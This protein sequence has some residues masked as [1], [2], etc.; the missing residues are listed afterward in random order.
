MHI[1][2]IYCYYQQPYVKIIRFINII[3]N[4]IPFLLKI[5]YMCIERE[6]D[7]EREFLEECARNCKQWLILG[8]RKGD[9]VRREK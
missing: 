1:L 6:T 8:S 9:T 4:K 3:L 7:W 5:I 2:V